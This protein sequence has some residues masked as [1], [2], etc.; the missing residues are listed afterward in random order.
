MAE[1][2]H[3]PGP[4]SPA[5]RLSLMIAG[6][7]SGQYRTRKRYILREG[8]VF[9]D[10]LEYQQRRQFWAAHALNDPR[11]Q[12]SGYGEWQVLAVGS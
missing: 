5:R 7:T 12:G 2:T 3:L 4:W 9:E 11:E 1:G 6:A 8:V 10:G